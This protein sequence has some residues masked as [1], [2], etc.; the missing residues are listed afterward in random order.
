M[1]SR[2][3]GASADGITSVCGSCPTKNGVSPNSRP[4]NKLVS[5]RRNI[6]VTPARRSSHNRCPTPSSGCHRDAEGRLYIISI[7]NSF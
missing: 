1:S 6:R 4:A 7:S 5:R 3:A 2:D